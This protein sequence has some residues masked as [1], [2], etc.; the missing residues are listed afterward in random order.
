MKCPYCFNDNS[1]LMETTKLKDRV[2]KISLCFSCGRKFS[3]WEDKDDYI[4][5][6]TNNR[7][8]RLRRRF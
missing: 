3:T 6:R 2:K 1:R 8:Q 4:P 7:K 5:K